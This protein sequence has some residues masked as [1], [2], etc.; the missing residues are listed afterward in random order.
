[1]KKR[2]SEV[3]SQK[4]GLID[5]KK[6]HGHFSATQALVR[7]FGVRRSKQDF[8]DS[9]V[10]LIQQESGCQFVGIRVLNDSGYIPYQSFVGFSREFWETENMI[11]VSKEDCV[12][13][14]IVGGQLLPCDMHVVNSSGSLCCNDTLAFAETLSTDEQKLYRGACNNAG[15]RSVAVVPIK[16]RDAVLGVVH[17][18][19]LV[20]QQLSLS[21]ME[22]VEDCARLVGEILSRDKM[23]RSLKITEDNRSILESIVTGI[24]SL[25]YVVDM[26]RY[27]LIYTS[28][29]F[30][31]LYHENMVG[32]KCFEIFGFLFPCAECIN[33]ADADDADGPAAWER[34][35]SVYDRYYF[36]E[37]KAINWPDGR[38][39]NAAFV[40]DVTRQRKAEAAEEK[41]RETLRRFQVFFVHSRDIMLFVDRVDGRIIEAN[42][43]AEVA[44]GYT[45]QEILNLGILDLR[46]CRNTRQ[47]SEQMNAAATVGITF[48][49]S[50]RRKDGSCFP[51]EV[52]SRGEQLGE[53]QLLFSVI[54]DITERKAAEEALLRSRDE[55]VENEKQLQ[56]S[57]AELVATNNELAA[58]NAELK[59][60]ANIVAHDFRTP[61]V[62]LQ[63]FTGELSRSLDELKQIIHAAELTIPP[64]VQEAVDELL[65]KDVPDAQKYINSSV[66]RLSRMIDALL[67]LARL[68]RRDM[69]YQPIA[70]NDLVSTVQQ[71]FYHAIEQGKVKVEVGPLPPITSDQLAIE[72]IISNFLDNAIK[73]LEPGRP[74]VIVI[75]GADN[76]GETVFCVADNGRG[77]AERDLEKIFE[78][79]GRAG[80][81]DVVGEG[82]GLAYV[83]T[84]IRQ[85]GGRVWCQSEP[86]VGTKM[87]FSLPNQPVH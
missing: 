59:S 21:T 31:E 11:Q 44:Y 38:L 57:A 67:K 66:D 33:S 48:E 30:D 72:Q 43:A 32:R 55:L 79:F 20:P 51:V 23:E 69:V 8:F 35:D 34:H 25:A 10:R 85:L 28:K 60:F 27:E 3:M 41:L 82:M 52:T 75:S 50:H 62:N 19:D 42:P 9:V 18:A 29:M 6:R 70:M 24:S 68:G 53:Q 77:I 4:A 45:R 87:F 84:L 58:A 37:R 80:R 14:R 76:G 74:G 15:Y 2:N 26:D 73:Y 16:S 22:F 54:R 71:S 12:C 1:M 46:A 56:L 78:I 63:G 49:T 13:T 64:Y 65:D 40:T 39:I 5:D 61:M 36:A 81:Q 47:A 17:V 83:R 86:G 7:S